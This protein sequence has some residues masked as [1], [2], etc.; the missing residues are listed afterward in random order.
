MPN[1]HVAMRVDVNTLLNEP[2]IVLQK[3]NFKILEKREQMLKDLLNSKVQFKVANNGVEQGV[4]HSFTNSH[5]T[6]KV[7]GQN[8]KVQIKKLI[9]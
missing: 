2:E 7:A 3:M 4:L 8:V 9:I 6:I 1:A 5:C